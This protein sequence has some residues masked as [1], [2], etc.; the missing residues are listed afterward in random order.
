[1]GGHRLFSAQLFLFVLQFTNCLH[2]PC[3][4][5]KLFTF[6][7]RKSKRT[8]AGLPCKCTNGAIRP[9]EDC[10]CSTTTL[11]SISRSASVART[12]GA[13]SRR[14]RRLYHVGSAVYITHR[15]RHITPT[16]SAISR[17]LC[18]LYLAPQGAYLA[19]RV[20]HVCKESISRPCARERA[21]MQRAFLF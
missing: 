1:M 15:R 20:L 4:I 11:P 12:A 2:S 18:R 16:L 10:P 14:L 5:Y 21:L 17:R 19:P 7:Q 13:I 8:Q 6:A 3:F 9:C